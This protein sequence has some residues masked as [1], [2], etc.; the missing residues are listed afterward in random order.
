[1]KIIDFIKDNMIIICPNNYKKYL[2]EIFYQE[3]KLLN[4]KFMTLDEYK[5]NYLFD[6]DIKT[7]FYLIKKYDMKVDNAI[8]LIN[9][10][11]YVENK[12]YSSE[13]LSYL[14][15]IKKELDDNNLLIYNKLFNNLIK[16]YNIAVI[17]YGKLDKF[18]FN[19]FPNDTLFYEEEID[20]K[21]FNIYHFSTIEE[22]MEYLFNE[23]S[24][25]LNK[26]ID[27][28]HIYLMNVNSEYYPYLKRFSSY[29]NIPIELKNEDSIIGT[30]IGK[31]FIALLNSCHSFEEISMGLESYKE[32]K[33]YITLIKILNKYV[34]FN[35]GDVIDLI[36]YDL[37]NT[38]L[39]D[40]KYTNLVRII[41]VDD[42]V[43][44]D[45]YVYLLGFNNPLIP[46]IKLDEDYITDNIKDEVVMSTTIELNKISK[47]NTLNN[48][49]RI[50][51]IKISY[52]DYTPF[53]QYYPSIL[54]EDMDYKIIEYHFNYQYSHAYNQ[55][56]YTYLL[57]DF[58]K[59]GIYH[60]DLE[61]LY[62]TYNDINYRKYNNQYTNINEKSFLAYLNNSLILSY[63]HIDNYYKC[64]FKYYLS[65]ILKIDIYEETFQTVIG[66]LF[67]EVLRHAFDNN[68][69]F[70]K[71]YNS[72]LQDKIFTNKEMFFLNK[73]KSD[74]L[75]V[76]ETIKEY[77]MITGFTKEL[78]E[79]KINIKLKNSP[80]VY[81][82]GF[83]DKIM[84]K[85]NPNETLVSIVDYKT[86]N[87]DIDINNLQFGLSMQLP[88]YLYLTK[89]S[90]LFQNIKFAG[91]YLQH[92]LNNEIKVDKKK[93]Y[94]EQKKDNLKLAG[95]STND[96]VRLASFDD[97]YENSEMIKGMKVKKDG[98]LSSTSHSLS[99][100]EMEMIIN[101]V[102]VKIKEAMDNILKTNFV[103]NPK[104]K[105]KLNL[106]CGFC[107]FR[108]ICYRNEKDFI[109]LKDEDEEEEG[110]KDA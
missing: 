73:L 29:Y 98:E 60:N 109:Y 110:E 20:K 5:K 89:N 106:S 22:E 66:N 8:T 25:L 38:K 41:N 59:Y 24:L 87:P 9:N 16:K 6:Y 55:V 56:K 57:D 97:T 49:S 54:L 7:I 50:K 78:Y 19:L 105:N 69:D 18:S 11:Y 42:L 102:D 17:G 36:I 37:T 46:N 13:K 31:K 94:L 71:H 51:N 58:V 93:S 53:N 48:I 27:I 108:D 43:D 62:N 47:L 28:N 79:E 74:L 91:F 44:D 32:N 63:S 103:I 15:K 1:M 82:K 80:S 39:S 10:L 30:T 107:K 99:D 26:N 35:L 64:G 23:I 52:K 90:N 70:D 88:V 40:I 61:T 67:H 101:L 68:F 65:N 86:G 100:E 84:Y 77:R 96:K 45:D 2:L 76:I 81:F 34:D 21:Q 83:V 4:I 33:L 92:I 72:F 14:V 75:F 12:K 85:E 104:I 95:Y 3:Q